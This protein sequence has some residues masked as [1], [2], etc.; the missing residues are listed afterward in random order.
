MKFSIVI[1]GA[2]W[3]SPSALSALQFAE[4]VLDSGHDIY[5]LF[6]YQDGVLN[7]SCLCVPPQDEEDIPARW[8]ALIESNDIDAVVCA[9]SALKRGILDKAEEDRYDKSGHNLRQGFTISG[10]GQ[11]IDATQQ[12]DRVISFVI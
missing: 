3:S 5:R 8:Q 9:A 11:L 2:P 10:L 4:T 7:S 6:F 12:S 1:N